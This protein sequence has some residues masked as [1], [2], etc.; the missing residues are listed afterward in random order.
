MPCA[1]YLYDKRIGTMH[2]YPGG[3]DRCMD[4][5]IN[6]TNSRNFGRKKVKPHGGAGKESG[7]DCANFHYT[8][9]LDSDGP[10][11]V[12][13]FLLKACHLRCLW[14][15][16]VST[17]HSRAIDLLKQMCCC[18]ACCK[19]VRKAQSAWKPGVWKVRALCSRSLHGTAARS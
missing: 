4:E 7:N 12:L 17:L 8:V 5:I 1:L 19:P 9:I 10:A 13:P 18:G 11:F 3:Y 14:W 2:Y 6:R 16:P 15:Q